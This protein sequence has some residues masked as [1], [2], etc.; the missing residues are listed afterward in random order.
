MKFSFD[1]LIFAAVIAGLV[2]GSEL[3]AQTIYSWTDENGI[4][5]FTDRQPET[6]QPVTVQ[7][8]IA[9]PESAL[10]IRRSGLEQ[11]PVWWFRNR[12][13]GP[14]SVRVRLV[15]EENVITEPPLPAVFVLPAQS[16]REL[17]TIGPLNPSRSWSYRFETEAIVGE[18]GVVHRPPGPYR[19]P[20]APGASFVIGQAFGG[21]FSHTAPHAYHAVDI[22][23]PVGT[24]I[25][26]ARAGVVMDRERYFHQAGQDLERFGPRANFVRILHDDGTM[27]VYAHLD[28]EGV[29]VFPG[30]QVE[31]GQYLGRSGNTGYS[32][33]PHL[34]FVIQKNRD[35]QLVSIPFEFEGA[36]GRAVTPRERLRLT[37]P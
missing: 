19:P 32:S 13:A 10:S 31:R 16:E 30:E 35:M 7:K 14:L 8:A 26:A 21:T 1:P 29:A 17:V 36:D 6:E 9:E 2:S 25:H 15:E 20:I 33:G 23:M 28:Y 12:L 5:H 3:T 11:D 24:P 34:H 27:A 22:A 4:T 37:A 18:M